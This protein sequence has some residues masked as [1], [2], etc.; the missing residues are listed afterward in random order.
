MWVAKFEQL[1]A[2]SAI[3]SINQ[4]GEPETALG[5]TGIVHRK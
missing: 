5:S 4:W 2:T 3:Q 1:S